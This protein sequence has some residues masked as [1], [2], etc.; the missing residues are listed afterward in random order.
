MIAR[1]FFVFLTSNSSYNSFS[2][3]Y[4]FL[5]K[6]YYS[7]ILHDI[8]YSLLWNFY[9]SYFLVQSLCK[10]I[11]ARFLLLHPLFWNLYELY[12]FPL[13][14]YC[15]LHLCIFGI[16]TDLY[17]PLPNFIH[18]LYPLPW[19]FYKSYHFL[20]VSVYINDCTFCILCPGICTNHISLY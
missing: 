9:K 18:F 8:L 7:Q 17:H 2:F 13:K 19:N 10:L 3:L 5:S 15:L 20:P 12:H 14:F 6:S 11:I 4:R 1:V 16:C